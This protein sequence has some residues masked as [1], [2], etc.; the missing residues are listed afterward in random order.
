MTRITSVMPAPPQEQL[1][2]SCAHIASAVGSVLQLH[3][4][5]THTHHC[6]CQPTGVAGLQRQVAKYRA[7]YTI[8]NKIEILSSDRTGDDTEGL[9]R[10][11]AAAVRTWR[12][13]VPGERWSGWTSSPVSSAAPVLVMPLDVQ[14]GHRTATAA[15]PP[16]PGPA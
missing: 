1:L 16:E 10:E 2:P 3:T 13:Q 9:P 12:Q 8:N 4:P 14:R 6:C 7:A 5:S 11:V 15:C